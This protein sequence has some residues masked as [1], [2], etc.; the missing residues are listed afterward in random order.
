MQEIFDALTKYGALGAV[1]L[2]ILGIM[3]GD[4]RTKF[5]LDRA[6]EEINRLAKV[7]SD[8]QTANTANATML[9][10]EFAVQ[11]NRLERENE[12][13]QRTLISALSGVARAAD[14]TERVVSVAEQRGALPAPK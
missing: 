11:R 13:L 10:E 3:R 4:F 5:E 7:I 12:Y 2:G 8:Q 14:L 9:R 6:N 1:V